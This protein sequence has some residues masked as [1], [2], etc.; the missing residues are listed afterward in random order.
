MPSDAVNWLRTQMRKAKARPEM[1]EKL[2]LL[3]LEPLNL[4]TVSFPDFAASQL[5][6]WTEAAREAGVKAE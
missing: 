4:S 1:L 5:P 3:G 2:A 6:L